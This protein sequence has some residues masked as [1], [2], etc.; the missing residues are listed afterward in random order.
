MRIYQKEEEL[1]LEMYLQDISSIR[2]LTAD[3][4]KE[5]S[6][7]YLHQEDQEAFDRLV[8][9]NLRLVINIAKKYLSCGLSFLDLI[10][11]G[12]IGLIKA[13]E[14]FNPEL[15]IRFSTYA[16]CWIKHS[17]CRALTE[18]SHTVRI[19]SYLK[20]VISN[21]KQVDLKLQDEL[22]HTPTTREIVQAMNVPTKNKEIVQSAIESQ[23]G[24]ERIQ[25]LHHNTVSKDLIS[26]HRLR[27]L[28]ESIIN[29]ENVEEIEMMLSKID[30]RQAEIIRMRFG[31]GGYE[32]MTL[33]EIGERIHLTKERIRQ[34]EHETIAKLQ[35]M[36]LR[37]HE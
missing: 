8:V 20:K 25:S 26:D 13:V 29:D 30:R 35:M 18:Q 22:G 5:L 6:R 23:R 12:N 16:T 34:L 33:K 2:L 15:N 24:I 21:W 4:E 27:H 31:L 37:Y 32:P 7:R 14:R 28:P 11:E 10:E 1:A 19:P 3:E 36:A 17:I 9:S